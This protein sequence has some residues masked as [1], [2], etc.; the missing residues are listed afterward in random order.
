ME[1]FEAAAELP[2]SERRA[3][4]ESISDSS[5]VGREV[6]ELL[7]KLE[8]PPVSSAA[9]PTIK[10]ERV[11]RYVV[12]ERLGRGGMGEVYSARD[13]ELDRTVALKF[14]ATESIGGHSSVERLIREAKAL[15]ALNH[16]NIVTVHEVIQSG[17][18]LRDRHGTGGRKASAGGHGCAAGSVPGFADRA[19][20]RPGS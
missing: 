19:T 3:F 10:P 2:P 12:L 13:T 8:A 5:D 16:P 9:T 6:L 4:L 11:G 18:H 1:V 7:E 14:L 20:G 17:A 15:S